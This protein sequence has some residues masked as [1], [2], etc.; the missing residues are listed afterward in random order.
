MTDKKN[1]SG[2]PVS[3]GADEKLDY[4]A[5]LVTPVD[6]RSRR[7]EKNTYSLSIQTND[8]GHQLVAGFSVCVD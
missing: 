1:E 5:N 4:L 2:F 8:S 3:G 6:L 7:A